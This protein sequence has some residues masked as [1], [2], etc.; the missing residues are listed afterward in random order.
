MKVTKVEDRSD[1]LKW[2]CRKQEKGKRHKVEA[3]IRKDSWFQKSNLTLE[4]QLKITY[5]W[6]CEL[7]Q[8]QIRH[9]LGISGNTGVDWDSYCREICEVNLLENGEMLGGEGKEVQIDESKFGKREYH[10]GHR[11]EGQWVFGEIDSDSR[12]CS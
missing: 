11:V 1:G 6:C 5:W 9:E 2:E 4:E 7:N 8:K 12:G 10:R 3:S